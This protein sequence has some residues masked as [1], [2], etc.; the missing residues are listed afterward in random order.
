MWEQSG[1]F[2]TYL[3]V[4][5]V[6]IQGV[7]SAWRLFQW[8]E[9]V[10]IELKLGGITLQPG[11]VVSCP[12][13]G[14]RNGQTTGFEKGEV[15]RSGDPFRLRGTD[16]L[17]QVACLDPRGLEL[18]AVTWSHRLQVCNRII[19]VVEVWRRVAGSS[20][21]SCWRM[22]KQMSLHSRSIHRISSLR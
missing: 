19:D 20:F 8:S 11:Q 14:A 1:L 18:F 16:G 4:L 13:T 6:G 7:F 17:E 22:C 12:S 21:L 2:V 3:L 9:C 15:S 10:P 5:V